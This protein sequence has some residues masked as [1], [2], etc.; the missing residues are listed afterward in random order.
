MERKQLLDLAITLS[1]LAIAAVVVWSI[2]SPGG[3]APS[4]AALWRATANGARKFAYPW[5][6]LAVIADARY[7]QAVAPYG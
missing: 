2:V 3:E 7:H 4:K 1:Q 5:N 6:R